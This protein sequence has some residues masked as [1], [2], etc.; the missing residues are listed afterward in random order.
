[1]R[2]MRMPDGLATELDAWERDA[3]ITA[4]Q[5]RAIL[6]R[7]DHTTD[8]QQAEAMLT[9]LSLVVAGIGAV[10]LVAWNWNAIGATWKIVLTAG[11]TIALYGAAA[12][13]GGRGR[14]TLAEYC[15]LLA[16]LFAGGVIY[17]VAD[18]RHVDPRHTNTVMLW[19]FVLAMTAVL[20][21]SAIT[22]GVATAISAWWILMQAGPPPPPWAFLGIWPAL[23]LTVERTRNRWAAGGVALVFGY[24]VFFIVLD[25][26]KEHPTAGAIGALLAGNWVYTLAMRPPSHRPAFARATPALVLTLLGLVFLLPTG[27]HRAMTDWHRNAGQVWPA[28]VL[29]AALVAGTCWNLAQ[30]H[31]WRS[32]PAGLTILAVLWL[33]VWFT[34]PP[35]LRADAT[36]AWTWTIMFSAAVILLAAGAVRDAAQSR[37]FGQLAVGL[38]AI[39]VFVI[40]RVV[41]ARSLFLSGML[42]IGSALLLL[43]L[44]RAWLHRY[45]IPES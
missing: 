36:L 3:L 38:A 18:L 34:I 24:W 35:H 1:M 40:V 44:S 31:S 14:R 25:V 42:L 41:D 5:R 30:S 8:A 39:L 12:I 22:A 43:W 2:G 29:L 20:T 21:P 10:V 9:W 19:A 33:A 6:A 37:D 13:A 7:Y 17:V 16:A 45:T 28:L 4:D 26:W 11:P 23:A 32:R 27:A 15:G